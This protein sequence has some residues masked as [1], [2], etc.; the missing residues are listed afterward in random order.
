MKEQI[1][2]AGHLNMTVKVY[3][4]IILSHAPLSFLI[5]FS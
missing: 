4:G 1:V 2:D 3:D 5:A